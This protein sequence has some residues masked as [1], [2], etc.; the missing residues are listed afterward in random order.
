MKINRFFTDILRANL[1]NPRSRGATDELTNRVFLRV[2]KHG[3]ESVQDGERVHVADDEPRLDSSGYKANFNERHKHLA[4]IRNGAAGFGVVC[5]AVDSET[6]NAR[7]IDTFDKTTLLQLGT[8]SKEDGRTYAHIDARVPVGELTL[9][10]PSTED[11]LI[12]SRK[13]IDATIKAALVNARV[14]QGKFRSEVLEL[15]GN[16]CAV[17]GSVTVD[18]IRA[19]HIKPWRHS[20]DEER[21]DP[22]NGLPLVASL[23]AL[24]DTGLISFASS[25]TLIVS[26]VLS[27]SERQI[28][29]L[30]SQSLIKAP[31]QKT[32]EYLA[33]HRD[34]VFRK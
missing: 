7:K 30:D 17:T 29:G 16:R 32:V 3:I 1:R 34:S 33:Y 4:L 19:S 14:G 27:K 28:F 2:W 18:A 6:T 24:F 20:T 23:D 5:T 9:D 13:K 8:F 11:V 31:P 10:N 21:L 25:G 26:S 12:I 22:N 15:W